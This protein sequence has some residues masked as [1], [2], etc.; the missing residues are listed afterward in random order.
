MRVK[1]SH[2]FI[3]E[4]EKAVSILRG[5]LA[6]NKILKYKQI[7]SRGA[8]MPRFGQMKLRAKTVTLLKL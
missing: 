4:E 1:V 2:A 5:A 3:L 7:V 8:S 6:L